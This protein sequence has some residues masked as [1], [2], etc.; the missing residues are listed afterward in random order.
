[1][2]T[3]RMYTKVKFDRQISDEEF[4]FAPGSF[5][6]TMRG[7]DIQ[8]DF[9]TSEAFVLDDNSVEWQLSCPIDMFDVD[10]R[11][12]TS[13]DLKGISEIKEFFMCD[14]YDANEDPPKPLSI[15]YIM[16]EWMSWPDVDDIVQIDVAPAVV[17][18][19]EFEW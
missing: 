10:P 7:K 13:E 5:T 2:S 14:D 17:N 1:M 4:I 6:M 19:Y 9:N 15:E 16:F 18:A 12:I 8:F 3:F 11:T